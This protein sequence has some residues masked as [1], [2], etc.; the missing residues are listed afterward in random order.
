MFVVGAGAASAV[1]LG[2]VV[3][4]AKD[5]AG[6]D[7]IVLS[8]LLFWLMFVMLLLLLFVGVVTE[9]SSDFVVFCTQMKRDIALESAASTHR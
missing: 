5:I 2:G 7:R 4:A 1:G 6:C 3:A 9:E 8:A